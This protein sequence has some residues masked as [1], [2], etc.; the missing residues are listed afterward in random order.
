MTLSEL[1]AAE[2]HRRIARDFTDRMQ[3]VTDWDLPA[4]EAGWTAR[5]VVDHLVTWLPSF[6]SGGGVALP[7]APTAT[8][9][10]VAAWTFHA[11]AVQTLLD[12][13]ERAATPFSHPQVGS[14]P[15][16]EAVDRFY[17]PDIF[18]HTWD[19]ARASGQDVTL[20]PEFCT[21]LLAG[22]EPMEDAMRSS[23]QYGPKVEVPADADPQTR[24]IGFIGRDPSWR[25]DAPAS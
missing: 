6:L 1:T 18:M 7:V 10:P 8:D 17:T 15:A 25:P 23:G 9:D 20:E 11:D 5:H 21:E 16:N 12:D 14:M 22:M 2:R 24:L 4:P 19:L 3:R 13:P